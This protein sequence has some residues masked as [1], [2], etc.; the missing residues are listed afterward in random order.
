MPR[1]SAIMAP[2]KTI[3]FISDTHGTLDPAAYAALAD[4][5][6]IIHAGDIG[7]PSVLTE[8]RCLAPTIAVLGNNDFPEYGSDV[9][10]FAIPEI[11]GVRFLVG[12]EPIYVTPRAFPQRLKPGDPIPDVIVHGHV[13]Y[14]RLEWGSSVRPAKLLL[15]PGAVLRPRNGSVRT[16]AKMQVEDGRILR[17]WVEDLRG[18]QLMTFPA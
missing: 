5:D 11:E 17:A 9:D 10:H 8:L 18:N 3:G 7:R 16:I 2:M 6:V 14:P 4:S 12:H 1:T 15:C 13:H